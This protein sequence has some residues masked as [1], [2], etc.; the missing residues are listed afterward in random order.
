MEA[1][2]RIVDSNA[3]TQATAIRVLG[4]LTDYCPTATALACTNGKTHHATSVL[5]VTTKL[6]AI[7]AMSALADIQT[8]NRCAR[9]KRI[10]AIM[11][12]R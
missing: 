2:I 4:S 5:L 6:L 1:T 3:R 9:M 11:R 8:A 12:H 7:D 10:A